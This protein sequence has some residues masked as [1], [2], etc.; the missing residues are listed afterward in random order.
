MDSKPSLLTAK[1]HRPP[2][3][4]DGDYASKPS[5][6]DI[7]ERILVMLINE[8]VDALYLQ[9]ASEQDIELAMTKGVNYPKGLISWGREYGFDWCE[10]KLDALYNQYH[11]DRYRCSSLIRKWSK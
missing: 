6:E 2:Y 4:S 5:F 3:G 10:K 8:A 9:I 11:E 1:D 7:F